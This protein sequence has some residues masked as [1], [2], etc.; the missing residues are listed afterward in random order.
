MCVSASERAGC[1]ARG[2]LIFMGA[3]RTCAGTPNAASRP[4]GTHRQCPR[5]PLL[6]AASPP[7][8]SGSGT[9]CVNSFVPFSFT[10]ARVATPSPLHIVRRPAR[11]GSFRPRGNSPEPRG[12]CAARRSV[13]RRRFEAMVFQ[14]SGCHV[15]GFMTPP[16]SRPAPPPPSRTKWTRLVHPSVLTGHVSS[17][18][19]VT[20]PNSRPAP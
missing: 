14:V 20:P 6:P 10:S 11:G 13:F 1:G 18:Y 8:A 15:R 3:D 9:R 19:S 5:A 4:S 2:F 12:R 7:P 16:N 17:L